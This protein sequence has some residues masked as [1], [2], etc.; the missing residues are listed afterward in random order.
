M[1]I[2]EKSEADVLKE[3]QSGA[4][5]NCYLIYNRK[6][7]DEP[8][9]QKNSIKY[10]KLENARFVLK[11]RL[12]IAN[13]SLKGFC[14]DGIIS[15]KHS[16]FKEDTTLVFGKG[17]TVQYRIERPKFYKL[18]EFLNNGYFKGVI[19][20]CWDR[21]S[22]NK[23]DNTVIEK[24][25]KQGADFRFALATY[26]KTSSGA[27]HMDIDGMFAQHHSRVTS[28]KVKLSTQNQ[29]SKGFCTYKAP[30][31]YLNPGTV[32]NKPID[33]TRA[34]VIIQLFEKYATGEWSLESLARWANDQGMTMPPT[35]QRRTSEEI[36]AEEANDDPTQLEAICRPL[37]ANS[38]HKILINPFYTGKIRG[39]DRQ[40]IKSASH[41]ALI[42]DE[43]FVSVQRLLN[44]RN[45]SIHYTSNLSYPYRGLIRCADC[46]R[47]YTPYMQKG[48]TYY[49]T[50]CKAGCSNTKRSFN[51]SF[52]E[53]GIG[54]LLAKLSFT[55][56]ELDELNARA[57]TDI[58]LFES[59]RNRDVEGIERK[60][61]KV[62]EDLTYL[63][64]NKLVL[65]RT[66]VYNP[67]TYLEEEAKL[68]GEL[69]NLQNEE[70]ASDAS[71][72]EVIKDVIELS[73]LLKDL[74][75]TYKKAKTTEK[76]EIMRKLFSELF[77]SEKTLVIKYKKGLQVL[78]NRFISS[79]APKVWISEAV[80]NHKL[81]RESIQ[82]ITA[83]ANEMRPP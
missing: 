14:A 23:G 48:I 50:R 54:K 22:R 82:D 17:S 34:P 76:E 8:E 68:D 46:K 6:S 5:R 16:G 61:R 81:I 70:Q 59:K 63:R 73:E 77:L 11:E 49:G 60:K 57:Q 43:L 65:L 30:V 79:C 15:E 18:V 37:K 13:F 35:R 45:L 67:E 75:L 62:R 10:Q 66:G 32:E 42:S 33:P 52:F 3:I 40:F 51:I 74:Y 38:V 41:S 72:H 53:T 44:K 47:T 69:A 80:R 1:T 26:D 2:T 83:L 7:T 64:S 58:A 12:P 21:T 71:M 25:M 4:Y 55:K 56:E 20:L 36:L 31:G 78:E 24:L 39:N 19:S 27:L 28:E 29:R 9:N